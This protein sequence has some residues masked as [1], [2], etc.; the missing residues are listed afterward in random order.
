M[1]HTGGKN[2]TMMASGMDLCGDI[3][4]I[5]DLWQ[6]LE[7]LTYLQ[8]PREHGDDTWVNEGKDGHT[9]GYV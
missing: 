6:L 2:D 3:S 4:Y 7:S 9:R 5:V 8:R 1:Q